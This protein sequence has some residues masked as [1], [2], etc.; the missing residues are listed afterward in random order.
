MPFDGA[1]LI[2]PL[3]DTLDRLGIT[4]VERDVLEGHKI[5]Q[6]ERYPASWT[7]EHRHLLRG[8]LVLASFGNMVIAMLGSLVYTSAIIFGIHL[9]LLVGIVF[10]ATAC[11]L[12][13]VALFPSI[14]MRGPA[15]WYERVLPTY[16]GLA[17]MKA[18]DR[19]KRLAQRIQDNSRNQ[20]SFVY[21]ELRQGVELLDPY[22]LVQDEASGEEFVLAVWDGE[23]ILHIAA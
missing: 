12:L 4:P 20:L 22:I 10:L 7:Y 8:G 18:P 13:M 1:V 16:M 5:A 11:N 17:T 3:A 15:R 2:S 6:C 9:T 19:V 21:G 23:T 14:R